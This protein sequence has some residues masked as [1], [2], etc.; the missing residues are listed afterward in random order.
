M[1]LT[2]IYVIDD[3]TNEKRKFESM[4]EV[5]IFISKALNI[6]VDMKILYRNKSRKN[7]AYRRFYITTNENFK[8]KIYATSKLKK[9][10]QKTVKPSLNE[11]Q[12]QKWFSKK[13]RI[14]KS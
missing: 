11:R 5:A 7:R 8:P 9:A 2:E 10:V 14:I 13:T 3:L 1:P 12:N 4:I 6:E